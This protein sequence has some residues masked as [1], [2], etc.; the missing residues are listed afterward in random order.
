MKR[1]MGMLLLA[2]FAVVSASP[3]SAAEYVGTKK[4]KMCHM[5]QFKSWE[6]TKMAKAFEGLKPGMAVDAK[7]AAGLDPDK[8]Y[9]T[10]ASC[11][12]CHT[13]NGKADMPGVGCEACHGP[14]ADYIKVMMTNR[15]YTMDEIT[16]KGLVVPGEDSC[17]KCHNDK[18]PF[19]KGF[20]FDKNKGP[21]EHFP[22]KKQH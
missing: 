11:L 13:I 1:W 2:C 19:F 7:T 22:L 12:G 4:C 16:A 20:T 17:K 6:Q 15:D 18:S 3:V 5:K 21:H 10:D 9:T 14:G 8:D